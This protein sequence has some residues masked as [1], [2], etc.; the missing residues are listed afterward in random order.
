MIAGP[1]GSGKTTL[2]TR[3]REQSIE[4]GL[5]FNADDIARNLS[6]SAIEVMRKAQE[7]VRAGRA[8]ALAGGVDHSFETV[9]SH[10]SHVE[11]MREARAQGFV[12][13]LYFV[14]NDQPEI[15]VDRVANRVKHGGHDVPID[16]IINRYYG[17]LRNLPDAIA[18]SNEGIIFDNGSVENPLSAIAEIRE[19]NIVNI[20]LWNRLP[21]WW[22]CA[23]SLTL[24]FR[25][26]ERD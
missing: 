8:N 3:L 7:I 16:K 12:V 26:P 18:E 17:C 6:G 21:L 15:N 5:H 4:L 22:H 10:I 25:Q 2:V 11:Y 1:N 19:G 13:R 24:L 14:G 23:E 9:M 20:V